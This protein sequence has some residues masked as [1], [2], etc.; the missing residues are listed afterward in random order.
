MNTVL[1]KVCSDSLRN[2]AQEKHGV[3]LKASHA[4]ELAAAYFGYKSKNAMLADEKFPLKN[5]IQAEVVVM[6]PD[7]VI[8]KRRAS[9]EGLPAGLPDSYA[10][11][12]AF[13]E[14]IFASDA[15]G[16]EAP[17]FRSFQALAKFLFDRDEA[18]KSAFWLSPQGSL[19]HVVVVEDLGGKV[20]LTVYHLH[21][22]PTPEA[23][24]DGKTTISLSRIA[25]KI[26]FVNVKISPPEKWTAGARK[27]LKSLDVML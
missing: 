26:G 19:H 23:M 1:S 15:Y 6:T 4:H 18:C 8:D 22:P 27:S 3:K 12:G 5:L 24:V 16:S 20:L 14:P 21:Q 9:L 17:P 7:E 11:G 13:Y 25:G 2:F 10:L